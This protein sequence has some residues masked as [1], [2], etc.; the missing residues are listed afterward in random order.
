M[1]KEKLTFSPGAPVST[2]KLI[3]S[4]RH[5]VAAAD[6]IAH[7]IQLILM[8]SL[9]ASVHALRFQRRAL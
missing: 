4:A 6:A 8:L 5:A 7:A 9:P 1:L 3:I 2:P